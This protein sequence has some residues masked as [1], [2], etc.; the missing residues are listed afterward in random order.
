MS[1]GRA[2]GSIVIEAVLDNKDALN[3]IKSIEGAVGGL[4]NVV[5]KLGAAIGIA[6]SV[7]AIVQFGKESVQAA[8]ELSAALTGLQSILDGQGRSFSDA[9]KLLRNTQKTA[10]SPPQTLS[11]LIRIWQC[12]DMMT[13]RSGR[14]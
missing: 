8:N 14:C 13:A 4:K 9:K 5:K 7:G 1:Y 10:L 12:A 6:F 3:G 11:R 2:D